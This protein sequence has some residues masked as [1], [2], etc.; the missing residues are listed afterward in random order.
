MSK[1]GSKTA[2]RNAAAPTQFEPLLDIH[3]ASAALNAAPA[4]VR[5]LAHEG[6]LDTVNVGRA[7]RFSPAAIRRFIETGGAE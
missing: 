2:A 5:K 3:Q 4:T 6:K 1:P 7:L